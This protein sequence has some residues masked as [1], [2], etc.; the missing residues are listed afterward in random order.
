[1]MTCLDC[2]YG[3]KL[4]TYVRDNIYQEDL[5]CLRGYTS[6]VVP[7]TLYQCS[8]VQPELCDDFEDRRISL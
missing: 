8:C 1:M 5:V 3:H 7:Q 4:L 2:F 6:N